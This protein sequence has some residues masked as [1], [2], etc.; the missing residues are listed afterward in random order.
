MLTDLFARICSP[1]LHCV[2]CLSCP[3]CHW[4]TSLCLAKF[5]LISHCYKNC[6]DRCDDFRPSF[7][8]KVIILCSPTS[9][10]QLSI[11]PRYRYNLILPHTPF[12]TVLHILLFFL[13][14][15]ISGDPTMGPCFGL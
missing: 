15:T 2:E 4:L 5:E 14:C 1:I 12:S 10:P 13:D 11:L 7:Y 8:L 9:F 3:Q 6:L